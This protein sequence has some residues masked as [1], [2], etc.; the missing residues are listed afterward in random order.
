MQRAPVCSKPPEGR[1]PGPKGREQSRFT[2]ASRSAASCPSPKSGARLRI[3]AKGMRARHRL[4]RLCILHQKACREA[5]FMPE[6]EGYARLPR[7]HRSYH[8]STTRPSQNRVP[9][10]EGSRNPIFWRIGKSAAKRY[11]KSC[12]FSTKLTKQSQKSCPAALKRRQ[13][14]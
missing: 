8:L 3:L 13:K 14:S 5:D 9:R 1:L 11:Q 7:A 6:P 4:S 10:S 12:A 2:A